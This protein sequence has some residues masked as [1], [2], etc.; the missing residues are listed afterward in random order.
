MFCW[1]SLNADA[2]SIS[3]L[4]NLMTDHPPIQTRR[5]DDMLIKNVH[6]IDIHMDDNG[7]FYAWK[8]RKKLTANTLSSLEKKLSP[9]ARSVKGCIF[10]WGTRREVEVIDIRAPR[11]NSYWQKERVI[12]A[13]G[14]EADSPVYHI[15]DEV[16]AELEAHDAEYKK[17][18][19]AK[20]QEDE[21]MREN[22]SRIMD[23]LRR[24]TKDDLTAPP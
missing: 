4:P 24:I 10:D 1:K 16:F 7:Q 20:N 11:K 13:N 15:D 2:H 9:P 14:S 8:D 21:A 22:R 5:R 19:D 3:E 17:W 18:H 6:G 12:L 23:K